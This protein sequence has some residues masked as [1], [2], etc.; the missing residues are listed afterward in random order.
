MNINADTKIIARFH[1]KVS[2]R[3]LN[4]YNPYF[5]EMGINAL[6]ILF[7][8]PEPEPLITSMKTLNFSGAVAVGFESNPKLPP[9]LDEVDDIAKYVGRVGFIYRDG[10][11]Y[12]GSNQGGQGLLRAILQ[13]TSIENK[14]IVLVGAGNVAKGLLFNIKKQF[15]SALPK[16][17]IVNRTVENAEKLKQDFSMVTDIKSLNDLE[18]L[19]GDILVNAS[20]LGGSVQDNIYTEGIIKNFKSVADVTFETENTNLVNTAKKLGLE[21][22]T[23]WDM[24]TYQGQVVLETILNIKIDKEILKKHV[25]SGLSETVK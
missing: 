19:S 15:S 16:I 5:Q 7:H 20:D 25:V 6:F 3:G 2:P 21:V 23:G 12:V 9:L 10:N 24:F 13:T 14:R 11:K 4:I 8:N 22:A 17:T 18:T 1:T